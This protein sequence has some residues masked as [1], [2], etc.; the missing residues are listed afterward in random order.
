MSRPAE[1]RLDHGG[2]TFLLAVTRD[3]DGRATGIWAVRALLEPTDQAQAARRSAQAAMQ[4][5]RSATLVS[6]ELKT[7]PARVLAEEARAGGI[8]RKIA[9]ALSAGDPRERNVA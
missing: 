8:A 5:I 3:G 1:I 2:A 9:D 4:V 7:R 6:H